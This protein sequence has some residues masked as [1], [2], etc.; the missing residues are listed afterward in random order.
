MPNAPLTLTDAG[1]AALVDAQNGVIDSIT[2]TE[3]GLTNLGFVPSADL[4]ALPGEMFRVDTV[5]GLA[6]D[7]R[8]IHLTVTEA[9]S[10]VYTVRGFGL[11]LDDGTLFATYGQLS[12]IFAKGSAAAFVL[13]LDIQLG[14]GDAMLV[15]F[16]DTNFAY[17][18]ASATVAG[19]LE[20][21][22]QAEVDAGTDPARAVTPA[23]LGDRLN[24]FLLKATR[25]AA[26]GVASLDAGGKVPSAQLPAL[27]L[28]DVFVVASQ[29]AM[30]ALT[31]DPGD[32][33]VRTDESKTY[34]LSASPA[35]TLGNWVEILFPVAVSSVNGQTGDV[36]L[37]PADIGAVPA[38]RQVATSGL[39]TG[40]GTLAADRTIDVAKATPAQIRAGTNDA[41]A[42]TP[43]QL[44][45]AY[46][47]SA[48]GSGYATW[49]DG[50]MIQWGRYPNSM[51]EGDT[52]PIT[53]PIAFEAE[54]YVILLTPSVEPGTGSLDFF[55]V[56]VQTKARSPTGFEFFVQGPNGIRTLRAVDWVAIGPGAP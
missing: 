10:G 24:D 45:A 29:A 40:G 17:P 12:T 49:A 38:A 36:V 25:G 1:L 23:T 52:V 42:I 27:A 39:A 28:T 15:S 3:V 4:T 13:A 43:A 41:T 8:T 54:P 35:T 53:F 46:P 32:W 26:N 44:L 51:N 18:P 6:V 55:D 56:W 37:D 21:A 19:V 47:A 14:P 22:T 50:L 33:A 7:D 31:A 20:L 34:V 11:Y 5:A 2:I 30:L 48:G 9:G 16:G